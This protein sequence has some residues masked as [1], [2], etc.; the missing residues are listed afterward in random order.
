MQNVET[1]KVRAGPM[2]T[3]EIVGMRLLVLRFDKRLDIVYSSGRWRQS[4]TA[5]HALGL[6]MA[7]P[8]SA[9][10]QKNYRVILI[11]M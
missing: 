10:Q 3:K 4:S 8:E 9:T 5:L 7:G 1:G 11:G 6:A 2:E